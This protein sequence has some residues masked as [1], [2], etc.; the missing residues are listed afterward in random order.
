MG[1]RHGVLRRVMRDT[2]PPADL[3]QSKARPAARAE[4]AASPSRGRT[5]RSSLV[6]GDAIGK[7]AEDIEVAVVP[8][9]LLDQVSDDVPQRD[10]LARV[11]VAGY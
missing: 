11:A 10:R 8:G 9:G 7:F 3:R 2:R 6:A 5:T 1:V 4:Y